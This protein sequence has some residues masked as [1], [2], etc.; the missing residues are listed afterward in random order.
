MTGAGWWLQ[1][2]V[3]VG[4]AAAAAA[5]TAASFLRAGGRLHAASTTVTTM[6]TKAVQHGHKQGGVAVVLSVIG[7]VAIIVLIVLLG[8]LSARRR[9]RDAPPGQ[10]LLRGKG[11]RQSGRGLFG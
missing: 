3:G 4:P 7:L 8:S 5:A 6:T 11:P 10:G 2:G 9:T 1:S